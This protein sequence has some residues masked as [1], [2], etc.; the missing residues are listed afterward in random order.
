MLGDYMAFC[1]FIIVLGSGLA[2]ALNKGGYAFRLCDVLVFDLLGIGVFT[3][4]FG[5]SYFISRLL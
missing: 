3:I 1:V 4:S 5:L 2:Y